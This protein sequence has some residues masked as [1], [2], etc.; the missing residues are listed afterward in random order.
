MLRVILGVA[1]LLV[2]GQA[3]RAQDKKDPPK[4]PERWEKNIA[5]FEE[6]DAKDPPPKNAILFVGSS[7]IVRW[8]LPKS[9]P[10]LKAI[11]RGFGGS[12]I[13]DSVHFAPRLVL[14]HEPR[15]IVFYAGD[16]DLG[17]KKSPQQ[18]FEDFQAFVK[19]VRAALPETKIIF[20]GIKPSPSRWKIVDQQREA[21]GLIQQFCAK[22]QRLVFLDVFP[23]MLGEDGMP[24]AELYAKDNLHL[25]DKGYQVWND[26]LRPLLR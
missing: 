2:T 16:N 26:L 18:V 6:K 20:V 10:E 5:A 8:D 13:A 25:S 3:M 12:Q 17:A 23:A 14:K 1:F 11:N 9:F 4:G 19:L 21:N 7:S 24:R 22:D 15:T